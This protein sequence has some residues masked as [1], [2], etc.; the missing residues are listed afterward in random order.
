MW[1]HGWAR[2]VGG[3][4]W[5]LGGREGVC[6]DLIRWSVG[7]SVCGAGVPNRVERGDRNLEKGGAS[8]KDSRI[9]Q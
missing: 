4:R 1:W 7:W 8:V 3:W 2:G 9:N 5:C 6:E